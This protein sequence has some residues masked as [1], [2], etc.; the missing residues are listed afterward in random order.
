[1]RKHK[2]KKQ[3]EFE[4][5]VSPAKLLAMRQINAIE[6]NIIA[7]V[8]HFNGNGYQGYTESNA[9]IAKKFGVNRRTIINAIQRLRA[10]RMIKDIGPDDYHRCL[11]LS[12]E[13]SSLFEGGNGERIAPLEKSKK[14]QKP[15]AQEVTE[16]AQSI[17]YQLDG[18]RF[19]NHYESN[20]WKVGKNKMKDWQAAVKNWKF[21]D[22][23]GCNKNI[24]S[25]ES[26]EP[27]IR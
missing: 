4:Y 27:Y 16:Y 10:K 9:V 24:G 1:M 23:D 14:F 11:K 8:G 20:G 13:V 25:S 21:R 19:V 5:L 18:E 22:S 2:V 6:K 12:G 15:T 17:D 3:S 7:Q 26:A